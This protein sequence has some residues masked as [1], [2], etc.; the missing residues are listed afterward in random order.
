MILTCFT[1]SNSSIIIMRTVC[2]RVCTAT[3]D[4]ELLTSTPQA[5]K[6]YWPLST[7]KECT[8]VSNRNCGREWEKE[9][10]KRKKY[11]L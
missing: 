8:T 10:V 2:V 3:A 9:K 4:V 11:A 1:A 6:E 5:F 7:T